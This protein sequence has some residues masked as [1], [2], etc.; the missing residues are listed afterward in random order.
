MFELVRKS[1]ITEDGKHYTNYYLRLSNGSYIAIKPAFN[2][3][4]KT[5]YV[6]SV[7]EN[8]VKEE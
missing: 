3:D 2:N 7:E 6:L 4:Y 1:V 8:K 5:L